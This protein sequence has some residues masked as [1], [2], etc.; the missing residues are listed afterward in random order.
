MDCQNGR[1]RHRQGTGGRPQRGPGICEGGAD[2]GPGGSVAGATGDED[3]EQ[4][5]ASGERG[6]GGGLRRTILFEDQLLASGAMFTRRL[7]FR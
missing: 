3:L 6:G 1:G 7:A 2:H 4:R 5:A